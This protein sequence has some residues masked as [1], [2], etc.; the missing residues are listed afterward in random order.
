[1]LNFQLVSDQKPGARHNEDLFGFKGDTFW[2]LD[3]ATSTDGPPMARDA[4]WLVH[5]LDT[6]L[7]VLATRELPVDVMAATACTH[8]ADRWPSLSTRRPVAAMAVW[9]IHD[10]QLE[11]AI[12][13]NVSLLVPQGLKV[14]ELTDDRIHAAQLGS[15]K[16]LF[17]AL[18]RG[19]S[20]ESEEVQALRRS[21][22]EQDAA[23]LD[24]H[25]NGWLA[26][27][28]HRVPGDF[29]QFSLSLA[30]PAPRMAAPMMA[31]TDG[32]M[33]LRRYLQSRDVTDFMET[34][35]GLFGGLPAAIRELRAFE[36]LP[37][38]GQRFPRTKRH[39]D[40]TVV[41]LQLP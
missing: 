17:E 9:R 14:V 8:V 34:A 6:A 32:F 2:L 36:L 39:D 15:E 24:I 40:A 22:K 7:N 3:G 35:C 20:F 41:L 4:H 21:M 1:M 28:A 19:L 37:D 30:G 25:A 31:A 27:A 13:G 26:S 33:E 18:A 12:T 10:G 11:A 16:A 38:S 5:E 29:R 23:A